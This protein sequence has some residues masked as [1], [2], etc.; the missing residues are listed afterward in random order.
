MD[1][2]AAKSIVDAYNAKREKFGLV[3]DRTYM[4]PTPLRVHKS[5]TAPSIA[6]KARALRKRKLAKKAD[7][8]CMLPYA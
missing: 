2:W 3:Y 8:K 1:C 4:L 6:I 5:L 7:S